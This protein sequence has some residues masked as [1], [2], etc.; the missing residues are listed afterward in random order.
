MPVRA[1]FLFL[2]LLCTSCEEL[3]IDPESIF[4]KDSIVQIPL[5]THLNETVDGSSAHFN[6]IGNEFALEFSYT[7]TYS[8]IESAH[9]VN[10]PYYNW[11]D[12]TTDTVANFSNLDEGNYTFYVKSKYDEIEEIQPHV[13][14]SIEIN[15]ISGPSLRIYPQNQIASFGD[16]IDVFLFFEDVPQESAVTG[17]HVDIYINAV[18][19]EFIPGSYELGKLVTQFSGTT[20]YPTPSYSEDGT[21]MSID[22]V[23]DKNGVGIYGTGPIAKFRIRVLA[24]SGKL[25][26]DIGSDGSYQDINNNPIVFS[27]MCF[28]TEVS[29]DTF[30]EM[31]CLI[32]FSFKNSPKLPSLINFNFS[33]I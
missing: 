12:W 1:V 5:V 3:A 33:E 22:G 31:I 27:K 24:S 21:T 29:T 30:F 26:I 2:I 10:Q 17:L 16:E 28:F 23:A 13:S 25:K 7:L 14:K 6:W 11:S 8:L 19:L 15:N 18:E 32:E 9:L 20:I 4:E